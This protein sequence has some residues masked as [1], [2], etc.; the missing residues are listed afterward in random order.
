[1][2]NS[3]AAGRRLARRLLIVQIGVIGLI[4]LALTTMSGRAGLGAL[5]GGMAVAI[6]SALMAW[7]VFAGPVAGAGVALTRM[8]GGLA[9]K[10][11]VIVVLLYLALVPLALDPLAVFGGLL[12]ALTINL[13][14]L[15]FK[16]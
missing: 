1:V 2:L 3:V 9:L 16:S 11:L 7:R 10:W 15:L 5:M 4:A 13:S 6:G 14:A 8:A 12:A